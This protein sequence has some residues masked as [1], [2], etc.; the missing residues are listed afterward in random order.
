MDTLRHTHHST[1]YKELCDRSID[2]KNF[3]AVSEQSHVTARQTKISIYFD[4]RDCF[5]SRTLI[6]GLLAGSLLESLATILI[7]EPSTVAVL[8]CW[9]SNYCF[10]VY[11]C[12]SMLVTLLQARTFLPAIPMKHFICLLTFNLAFLYQSS[13]METTPSIPI[14]QGYTQLERELALLLQ[15]TIFWTTWAA[16]LLMLAALYFGLTSS[17]FRSQSFYCFCHEAFLLI[18]KMIA[19]AGG[20]SIGSNLCLFVASFYAIIPLEYNESEFYFSTFCRL[21]LIVAVSIRE[22][23]VSHGGAHSKIGAEESDLLQIC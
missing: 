7:P 14:K 12:T 2:E 20:V 22:G 18:R 8:M 3:D 13:A 1:D 19:F 23:F 21:A 10:D 4:V 6:L 15:F 9:F 5:H 11:I 17:T 16:G